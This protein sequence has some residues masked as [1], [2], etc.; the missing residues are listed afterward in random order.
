MRITT[1]T[2]VAS[3]PRADVYTI[4]LYPTL[5]VLEFKGWIEGLKSVYKKP[6]V[7]SGPAAQVPEL[8]FMNTSSLDVVVLS[9]AEETVVDL[10]AALVS[11]RDLDN[12][13]RIAFTS[14]GL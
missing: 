5:H 8:I 2:N 9:E 4:V 7:V 13:D 10:V 12:V 14:G 6:I 1:K 3:L 11:H